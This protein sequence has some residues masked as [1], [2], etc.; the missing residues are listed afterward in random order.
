[1]SM[2]FLS[3]LFFGSQC[4][5]V[6]FTAEQI[7]LISIGINKTT[8]MVGKR[9]ERATIIGL[10][11]QTGQKSQFEELQFAPLWWMQ[12]ISKLNERRNNT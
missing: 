8:L 1:M 12:E 6:F 4:K 2:M 3:R 11:F 10:F 7:I 5:E 9:T